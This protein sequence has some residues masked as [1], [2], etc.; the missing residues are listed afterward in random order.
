MET[1]Q[2]GEEKITK[3]EEPAQPAQPSLVKK[4][5]WPKGV[6]RGPKNSSR[7]RGRGPGRPASRGR[8]RSKVSPVSR[9]DGVCLCVRVVYIHCFEACCD[10]ACLSE[11][12]AMVA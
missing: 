5:G 4:R 8:G 11:A 6:P 12:I 2:K 10:I 9:P 1:N 7:G 3:V